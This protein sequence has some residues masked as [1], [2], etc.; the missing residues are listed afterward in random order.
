MEHDH[1]RQ[2]VGRRR[3]RLLE[4]HHPGRSDL[5]RRWAPAATRSFSDVPITA[6]RVTFGTGPTYT[7]SGDT[8]T[9]SGAN[10]V[11]VDG[12]VTFDCE[13]DVV[14]S[15]W[16]KWGAGTLILTGPSYHSAYVNHADGVINIRHN[17]A[18][19][20]GYEHV[21]GD[22][23]L[24]VQDNI[25][26]A[27]TLYIGNTSQGRRDGQFPQR[28]RRQRVDR[29][30]LHPRHPRVRQG[31]RGDRQHADDQRADPAA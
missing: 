23:S 16:N 28:Q 7:L 27:N 12:Q 29:R 17:N 5:R 6:D 30:R 2:L 21:Y 20:T 1:L 24:E 11:T 26:V 3:Q 31:R 15:A 10:R 8:L 13:M 9:L 14:G 18:L 25:T 19:G 4:Q 22:G